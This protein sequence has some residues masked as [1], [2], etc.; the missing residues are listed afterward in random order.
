MIELNLHYLMLHCN[1]DRILSWEAGDGMVGND[2]F[3]CSIFISIAPKSY[4]ELLP[5]VT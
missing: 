4:L 3:W 5:K 2:F 1:Y